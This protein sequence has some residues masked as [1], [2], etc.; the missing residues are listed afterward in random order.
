MA[1][2]APLVGAI[3]ISGSAQVLARFAYRVLP[4][5]PHHLISG[6]SAR[7]LNSWPLRISLWI[8]SGF[9]SC[10]SGQ[11]RSALFLP[12]ACPLR[13]ALRLNVLPA[14]AR[15][16]SPYRTLDRSLPLVV[17]EDWFVGRPA[18]LVS[19][20][21]ELAI[22]NAPNEL[23]SLTDDRKID[24]LDDLSWISVGKT[25]GPRTV[26]SRH[27]EHLGADWQADI[28]IFRGQSL[29]HV[30]WP[31]RSKQGRGNARPSI[32][33]QRKGGAARRSAFV[34]PSSS[35]KDCSFM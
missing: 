33:L 31:I 20:E 4:G 3:P 28:G 14:R 11:N 23:P 30:E 24:V 32:A 6:E 9:P 35:D 22:I 34:G 16:L 1:P 21:A 18:H 26:M 29:R 19:D 8:P 2:T 15:R 13:L 7:K 17:R 25:L 5:R 12:L 27:K 10:G